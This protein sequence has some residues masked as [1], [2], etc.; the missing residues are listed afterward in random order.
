MTN[1]WRNERLYILLAVFVILVNVAIFMA[2]PQKKPVAAAKGSVPAQVIEETRRKSAESVFL[3]REELE[4]LLRDDKTLAV[5]LNLATLLILA[6]F[7]L[8]LLIDVFLIVLKSEKRGIDIRTGEALGA[9]RWGLRD[10]AKVVVL[11]LFFGYALV[12]IESFLAGVCPLIKNNNLRMMANSLVLDALAVVFIIY[13]T[14]GQY[15][16]KLVSLGLSAKNFVKNA[17]YGIV[18]YLAAVPLLVG[19]VAATALIASAL[20][21]VPEKQA[22]VRLFMQ[23]DDTRFLLFASLF[24]AVLGPV[25]EEIFFRG[26]LYNAIKK[27]IGL[28]WGMAATSA[29]F[30]ALHAH[31]VGFL[32]IMVIG[33][34]L[35]YLY[36]KT[37]TLV[38]P[39]TAHIIHNVS[40]VGFVFLIKQLQV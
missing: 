24:A 20:N 23:E 25:V 33:M 21:Y 12:L 32:P 3:K 22:V 27:R 29:A 39:I 26:F 17:Y 28:F 9:V 13:F 4:G 1:A 8:G 16:E 35:A 5:T 14:V 37:G 15:Q 31:P 18:G 38:A 36:E 40:M 2:G 11:F 19:I 10:V 30:A 6:V 7:L 34:L